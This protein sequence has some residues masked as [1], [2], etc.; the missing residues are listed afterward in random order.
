[1]V[2]T[3]NEVATKVGLSILEQGVT[4]SIP[5]WPSDLPWR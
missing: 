2:V 1:M 4:L 3:Q 5:R